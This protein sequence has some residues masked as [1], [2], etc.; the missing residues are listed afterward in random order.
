MGEDTA[1]RYE[2]LL[3]LPPGWLDI[4]HAAGSVPR[5][6]SSSPATAGAPAQTARTES[7]T[8]LELGEL[9]SLQAATL[10]FM[11]QLMRQNALTDLDAIDLLARAREK[12]QTESALQA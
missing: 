3:G 7:G 10:R 9:S 11:H 12:A 2:E 1:R 5:L 8:A 6:F 4:E